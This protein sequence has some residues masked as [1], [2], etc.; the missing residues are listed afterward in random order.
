VIRMKHHLAC[1]HVEVS[2]C[3]QVPDDAKQFFIDYI[4][5]LEK[6]NKKMLWMSNLRMKKRW[7][8]M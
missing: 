1:T 2:V 5:Q 3:P 7:K 8:K 6:K 4:A